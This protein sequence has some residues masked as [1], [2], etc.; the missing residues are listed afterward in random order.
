MCPTCAGA[1]WV[2]LDV[3]VGHPMFGRALPCDCLLRLQEE[4]RFDELLRL[5]KIEPFRDKTFATFDQQVFG[6]GRAYEICREY[7]KDPKGWLVL[8]GPYGC[9]KT[10]LAAAIANEA[11]GRNAKVLFTVVPDLLDHLRST[12]APTS[13]VQYDDLFDAVRTTPLLV[14]DDLGTEHPSS[15]AQ[16]K[17]YQIFNHR[18]NEQL[19]TVVTTNRRLEMLDERIASRL[20]D[21]ALSTII[22]LWE[23]RA[24]DY[25][26]RQVGERRSRS[27]GPVR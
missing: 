2:T 20:S 3:P 15:W 6:V 19:P 16:E 21:R 17:L 7:A 14:L 5:S 25:R 18:Y 26:P 10:H 8:M 11:V 27:R 23:T 12:F 22:D 24:R 9:G 1:G 13:P 4:R